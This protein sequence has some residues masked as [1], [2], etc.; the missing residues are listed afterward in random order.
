MHK[1]VAMRL[2]PAAGDQTKTGLDGEAVESGPIQAQI[3]SN[4][5][6]VFCAPPKT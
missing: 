6:S 5:L 3:F 4:V 2:V 1:C